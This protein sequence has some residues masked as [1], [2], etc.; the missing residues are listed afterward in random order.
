MGKSKF[1]ISII[2]FVVIFSTLIG[3]FQFFINNYFYKD[4][5]FA[6]AEKTAI[7]KESILKNLYT[8]GKYIAASITNHFNVKDKNLNLKL[9]FDTNHKISNITIYSKD[10][11]K[12]KSYSTNDYNIELKEKELKDFLKSSKKSTLSDIYLQSKN[13]KYLVPYI[14]KISYLSK[15]FQDGDLVGII[16][17][18]YNFI[19]KSTSLLNNDKYNFIIIDGLGNMLYHYENNKSWSKFKN[20]SE[21]FKLEFNSDYNDILNNKS[22]KRDDFYSYKLDVPILNELIL[23]LKIKDDYLSKENDLIVKKNVAF[24]LTI[25]ILTFLLLIILLIIIENSLEYYEKAKRLSN[26]L[27]KFQRFSNLAQ[28]VAKVGLWEVDEYNNLTWSKW[29]YKILDIHDNK[30]NLSYDLFISLIHPDDK[31]KF[32]LNYKQSKHQTEENLI[33]YRIVT[34]KGETKWVEQR[35]RHFYDNKNRFIKTIGS[36]IDIS[37]TKLLENNLNSKNSDLQLV[38]DTLEQSVVLI[39]LDMNY[40]SF[41]KS[42]EKLTGYTKKELLKRNLIDACF[43]SDRENFKLSLVEVIEKR[44]TV[45]IESRLFRRN[46]E[47]ITTNLS[48]KLMPNQKFILVA[49]N[50]ITHR[51]KDHEKYLINQSRMAN[52]GEMLIELTYQWRQPLSIISTS[53]S[54][55]KLEHELNSQQIEETIDVLSKI[56]ETANKLSNNIDDFKYYVEDRN[57]SFNFSINNAIEKVLIILEN[58]LFQNEISVI[59]D[60]DED[61]EINNVENAF[62]QVLVNIIKNSV[63]ALNSYPNQKKLIFI[64]TSIQK[65]LLEITITDNAH[66]IDPQIMPSI[67][68]EFF[69]TKADHKSSGLGLFLAKTIVNSR[70]KGD[71]SVKNREVEYENEKYSGASFKIAISLLNKEN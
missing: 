65:E 22:I 55:L 21:I 29:M 25:L 5:Y 48:F 16:A 9:F 54:F 4:D 50:D 14:P 38:L 32:D 58:S 41:N 15:V 35:W 37:E 8:E 11:Q 59:K 44:E 13:N 36:L 7:E 24:F 61:I 19:Y 26:E 69:T 67:F 30:K 18:E 33:T 17:I 46:G 42:Y 2:F 53:A 49:I 31:D 70:L 39:D 56:I 45:S 34:H 3:V 43:D 51:V 12:I 20:K 57:S 27:K 10:L 62:M 71:I 63:E 6:D 68:N 23:I 60:F 64:S 28:Q 52:L 40:I 47:I 1:K 66:G